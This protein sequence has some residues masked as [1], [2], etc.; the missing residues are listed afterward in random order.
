MLK[1]V[2]HLKKKVTSTLKK[3]A[4][5]VHDTKGT[6]INIQINHFEKLAHELRDLQNILA[7]EIEVDLKS[8]KVAKTRVEKPNNFFYRFKNHAELFDL[9]KQFQIDMDSGL[10]VFAFAGTSSQDQV[11]ATLLGIASYLNFQH[12]HKAL[13]LGHVEDNNFWSS[14]EGEGEQSLLNIQDMKMSVVDYQGIHFFDL[15]DLT[16][17][18]VDKAEKILSELTQKYDVVLVDIGFLE[19]LT[20]LPHGFFLISMIDNVSIV[21]ERQRSLLTPVEQMLGRFKQFNIPVKGFITR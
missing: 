20:Q 2:Q 15:N 11:D 1:Q 17:L 5:L 8:A 19:K 21:L 3:E 13:V 16:A 12:H 9:G 4:Q 7:D 6:V 10:S 18:S 14:L